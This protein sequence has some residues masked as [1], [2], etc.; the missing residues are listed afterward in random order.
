MFVLVNIQS[1]FF[2]HI[3]LA[4]HRFLE[5]IVTI[6]KKTLEKIIIYENEFN[7]MKLIVFFSATLKFTVLRNSLS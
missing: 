3:N 2:S 4:S 5:K 7:P 1:T 6:D